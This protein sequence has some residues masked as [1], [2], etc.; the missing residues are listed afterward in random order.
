LA[1]CFGIPSPKEDLDGSLVGPIYWQQND[2]E[3]IANYCKKDII[4]TAQIFMKYKLK[5]V[6]QEK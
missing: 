1:K 2:L 5:G 3:R 4:T 6:K